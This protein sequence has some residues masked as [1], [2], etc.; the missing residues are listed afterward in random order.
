MM[1]SKI[2]ENMPSRELTYPTW[3]PGEKENHLRKCLGRGYVSSQEGTPLLKNKVPFLTWHVSFAK[4]LIQPSKSP[5]KTMPNRHIYKTHTQKH[6]EH[7]HKHLAIEGL[8]CFIRSTCQWPIGCKLFIW[9]DSLLECGHR[10]DRHLVMV[11]FFSK[12]W[13][14]FGEV[15]CLFVGICLLIQILSNNSDYIWIKYAYSTL[16]I[17][18]MYIWWVLRKTLYAWVPSFNF[19]LGP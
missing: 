19:S 6:A 18:I 10:A 5:T 11:V 8:M 13:W 15:L 16:R 4:G 14:L 17:C 9:S 12:V 3:G 7:R 1:V 2:Q